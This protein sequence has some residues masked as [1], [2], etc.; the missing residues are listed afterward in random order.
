[1]VSSQNKRFGVA[2]HDVQPMEHTGAWAINTVFME[3]ALERGDVAAIGVVKFDGAAQMIAMVSL[4]HGHTDAFEHMPCGL[5]VPLREDSCTAEMPR[6]SKYT[7]QKARDRVV[8]RTGVR[9]S[10][11]PTSAAGTERIDAV[12]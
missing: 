10:T 8:R 1:M 7:K 2:E 9:W 6:S 4:P 5:I 12:R 11:S 3:I